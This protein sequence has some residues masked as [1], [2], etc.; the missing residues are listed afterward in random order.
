MYFLN[1]NIVA[2]KSISDNIYL[3][4]VLVCKVCPI[5]DACF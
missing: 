5:T 3:F 1:F 4:K 2:D